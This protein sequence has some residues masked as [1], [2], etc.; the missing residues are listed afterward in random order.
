[1]AVNN[2]ADFLVETLSQAGVK[3]IFGVVGDSLNG[4]TEAL[5]RHKAIDWIHVRHEE[6]AAFAAA[7]EA[8]ITGTLAVCA[9]SCGPGNLHLINGLFDCAPLARPRWWPSPPISPQPEIGVGL[10]SRRP[11][12]KQ[13][14]QRMQPV[15]ASWFRMPG[16]D[17]PRAGESRSARAVGGTL[18]GCVVVIPG[19][20]AMLPAADAPDHRT[21][22]GTASSCNR[23]CSPVGPG[24]WSAKL[25]EL[26]NGAGRVTLLC[27]G[28]CEGAHDELLQLA[29]ALKSADRARDAGQ[30]A[31]SSGTILT[32]WA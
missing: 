18:R 13:L 26:L 32:T 30:G 24:S 23:R 29:E 3:R 4:L 27:G 9:G 6:V 10:T 31:S 12:R 8:Q 5:R 21:Q 2:V 20:V 28:G 7:G 14:F 17:A 25:A 11:T 16:A 19:D 1:M 22:C 15:T